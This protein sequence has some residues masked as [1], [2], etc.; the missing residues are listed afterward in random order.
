MTG[1][2]ILANAKSKK[3]NYGILSVFAKFDYLKKFH[4][5]QVKEGDENIEKKGI[6]LILTYFHQLI[7]NKLL[8]RLP[9]L[10]AQIK[11]GNI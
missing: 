10:L 1:D 4:D 8:T 11:A 7:I 3:G 2:P 9:V 6:L 5:G